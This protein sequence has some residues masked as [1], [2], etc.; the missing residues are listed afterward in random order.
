MPRCSGIPAELLLFLAADGPEQYLVRQGFSQDCDFEFRSVP[1][2][3][4]SVVAVII[5]IVRVSRPR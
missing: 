4:G 3:S 2:T 5:M 1:L